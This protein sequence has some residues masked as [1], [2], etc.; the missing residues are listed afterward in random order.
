MSNPDSWLHFR[1]RLYSSEG[2]LGI[3]MCDRLTESG[4]H[5]KRVNKRSPAVMVEQELFELRRRRGNEALTH[6][7]L[8]VQTQA[9][10][11]GGRDTRVPYPLYGPAVRVWCWCIDMETHDR[12]GC[13]GFTFKWLITLRT[14]PFGSATQ[15]RRTPQGSS[16][17]G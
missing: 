8:I 15:K 9:F 14:V 16:V 12:A 17:N 1:I 2:G 3:A 4:C 5:V 7:L 13:F 6:C 10:Q 11:F